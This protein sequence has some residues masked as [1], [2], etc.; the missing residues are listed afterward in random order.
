MSSKFYLP[1]S[2]QWRRHFPV[3]P[4]IA[5]RVSLRNPH[6]A[7]AVAD[8]FVPKG[9]RDKVIIEAY[10]G[11]GQ[12]TRALLDLPKERIKKIIV[13][14]DYKNYLDYLHPLEVADPRVKVLPMGGFNW[15]SYLAIDE[16]Q[17]LSEVA[18]VAW[19]EGVHPSLHFIS[20]LPSSIDGEQLIAQLFRSIPDQQ[21]LFKY[22]RMPMSFVLSDHVWK[23]I[24]APL[25]APERC[26]LTIIAE[27]TAE[28]SPAVTSNSLIPYEYHF[29]PARIS[30]PPPSDR[31]K[32]NTR[33]VGNPFQAINIIPLEYQSIK[34]RQLDEWDFCLR[35]LFV[36]KSTA[37]RR[38]LPTLA[39]GAQ[40]LVDKVTDPSLPLSER[41]D[42]RK[43]VR[44]L[45]VE[46]W[47]LVVK[48]FHEWP[49]APVDLSITDT[50]ISKES[51][52]A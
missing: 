50:F 15:D 9:S 41:V 5:H 24:S 3:A 11:P 10:P 1:P 36:Q 18:Q 23:R 6:T 19:E 20:H 2:D 37:L 44:R 12:L 16:M 48:A 22:G 26:K 32:H 29:H 7:D 17:L 8:A 42:S 40:I 35:R 30:I 46:D 38:A 47:E 33:R 21:W 39:P 51:N 34:R 49:F 14:E 43:I 31:R 52:R 25:D 45:T 27:A 4:Y 28:C 13:L